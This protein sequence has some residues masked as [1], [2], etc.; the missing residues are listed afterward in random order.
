[1][2]FLFIFILIS[3]LLSCS[4]KPSAPV[5]QNSPLPNPNAPMAFFGPGNISQEMQREYAAKLQNAGLYNF[6]VENF[7]EEQIKNAVEIRLHY[8]EEVGK[9]QGIPALVLKAEFVKGDFVWFNF[10]IREKSDKDNLSNPRSKNNEKKFRQKILME[11][12]LE[13]VKRVSAPAE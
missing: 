7:S 13:E 3:L 8:I 2:R 12:F 4:V 1:M 10:T 11:R 6:V 5:F 9:F